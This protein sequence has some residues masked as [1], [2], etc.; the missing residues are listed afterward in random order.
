MEKNPPETGQERSP[1]DLVEQ[2]ADFIY[3]VDLEG[4]LTWFGK[5]AARAIF[6]CEPEELYG[7]KFSDFQSA[8]DAKNCNEACRRVLLGEAVINFCVPITGC[9]GEKSLLSVNAIAVRDPSGKVIGATGVAVDVTNRG[10]WSDPLKEVQKL[11][12]K[13]MADNFFSVVRANE[14]LMREISGRKKAEKSLRQSESR[15][16]NLIEKSPMGVHLYRLDEEGGKLV[17]TGGNPAADRIL[18]FDNQKF[19]GKFLE[20]A[21]PSLA[22]T[23][24]PDRYRRACLDGELWQAEQVVYEDGNVKGAFEVHALQTAPG[25]MASFFIDVTERKRFESSISRSQERFRAVFDNS[26]DAIFLLSLEGVVLDVNK[27]ACS[28]YGYTVEELI[29]KRLPD[30]DTPEHA[31]HIPERLAVLVK[32]GVAVFETDHRTKDGEI[33][34]TEV[35]ARLIK[36]GGQKVNLST[37][38]DIR[39]R[40]RAEKE[41]L[42]LERRVL[43]AQKLESLGVLTGGIAHDFNNILTVIQGNIEI[44]Q[45]RCGDV[46]ASKDNVTAIERAARKAT[47]LVQ[48]MLA[49][50]GKTRVTMENLDL[51]ELVRE[52]AEMISISVSKKAAVHTNL[53]PD[54]PPF[55]GDKDQ[56]HQIILNLIINASD[57]LGSKV[58]DITVT[59]GL[60]TAESAGI[61]GPDRGFLFLEVTDDGCGISKEEIDRIFDPFYTTKF[62][63]RGLGL[64]AVKGIVKA[65]NGLLTVE[66]LK[67]AGSTFRVYLPASQ[68]IGETAPRQDEAR[69]SAGVCGTVLVAD[70]EEAVQVVIVQLL[71]F[72]GFEVITASDGLDAVNVYRKNP[73]RFDLVILDMTMPVM[74]GIEALE[75]ILSVNRD[76]KIIL[77]SGYA[78][79]DLESRV[80]GRARFI[81]KPYRLKT[82]L[83][84]MEEVL[85]KKD[86]Q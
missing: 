32:N 42:E 56:I 38:R 37:C 75:E 22:N 27:T 14:A 34:P 4:R 9:T 20:E 51:S 11:P 45:L 59:T 66:S 3:T 7:R 31:V 82:L 73:G 40:R 24:I 86:S 60:A 15:L 12:Q 1:G 53:A 16:R 36:I 35:I 67:G 57:A 50:V 81:Q 65:H 21:F 55:E 28:R 39:E 79:K 8:E 13:Q 25:E 69:G 85:G 76:A 2:T 62:A 43:H 74:D 29:G 54:L 33:I 47:G 46:C 63:G 71:E 68:K 6:G 70:D 10:E 61:E 52:I 64:A 84:I 18:G 44:L 5:R 17:F 19:I 78:I 41:R 83:E 30:I 26:G 49:Y 23:E 77:A 48:Q 72:A 58:G 80:E